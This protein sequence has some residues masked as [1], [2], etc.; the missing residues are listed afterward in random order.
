MPWVLITGHLREGGSGDTA[1]RL[2]QIEA[3]LGS[4]AQLRRQER[5]AVWRSSLLG[6]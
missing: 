2:L 5:P 6:K 1:N 4:R 3:E